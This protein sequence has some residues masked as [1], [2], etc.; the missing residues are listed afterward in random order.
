M[1]KTRQNFEKDLKD[2][3]QDILRLGSLVELAIDLA[4]QSLVKQDQELA[5]QVIA[6]DQIIDEIEQEIEHKCIILI[7]TQ[8]PMA[9][10][11][12][13]I[14]AGFKI[15]TDLERMADY[16]VD[17]A[18]ST[19]RIVGEPLVKPLIDIPMMAKLVQKMV[20]D[21]LDAYVREDVDLAQK[22]GEDDHQVDHLYGTV[23]N[24]L[25]ELMT[26]EPSAVKQGSYLLFVARSLERIGDHAT[27]VAEDVVFL[28]TG[29]RKE[30]ND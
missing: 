29:E 2:L 16:A 11:L 20:R 3:R 10:D 6:G 9:K 18:R 5:E 8:Q 27:N 21:C 22:V 24:D 26:K 13:R 1:A 23:F 15:I 17:I 12:R 14:G 28:V 4:I 19:N 25:L 7:A 30:I